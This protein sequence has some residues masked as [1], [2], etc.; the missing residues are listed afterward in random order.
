MSLGLHDRGGLSRVLSVC[1]LLS[2]SWGCTLGPDFVRPKAPQADDYLTR[3]RLSQ[4]AVSPQAPQFDRAQG[5][6]PRWWESLGSAEINRLVERALAGNPTLASARAA[7]ERS[8]NAL[9]AGQGVFYPQLGLGASGIRERAAPL[10]LGS[11]APGSIFNLFTLTGSISYAIDLFGEK[12]RAVEGLAAQVDEQREV[13]RSAQLLLVANVV[14]TAI[15]QSAYRR[16]IEITDQVLALQQEQLD[17]IRKQIRGGLA[18]ASLEAALQQQSASTRATRHALAQRLDQAE[19]LLATLMGQSTESFS[20]EAPNLESLAIAGTLPL[21]LPSRLVRQRPDI[22]AA[23]ARIHQA[24]AALG[25]ATAVMLPEVSIGASAGLLSNRLPSLSAASER[26]WSEGSS[27]SMSLFSGGAQWY[28]REAARQL[29]TAAEQDYQATVLAAMAQVADSLTALAND[30]AQLQAQLEARDA[31]LENARLSRINYAGGLGA[32]LDTLSL[33][34]AVL[35]SHSLWVQALA[36]RHQ[37]AVALHT[38]LGGGWDDA[39]G[40]GKP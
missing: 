4:L 8:K 24:S 3:T 19:H 5:S 30:S 23:E 10:Q 22:V 29:L 32:Y 9:L 20:D 11:P 37:D 13:L 33:E 25:V 40:A 38:A 26:F 12:R 39:G 31:A 17:L 21:A 1:A 14:N 35:Q 36:V 7:L 2:L 27:A 16:E 18:A 6:I 28:G 15:A 34:V